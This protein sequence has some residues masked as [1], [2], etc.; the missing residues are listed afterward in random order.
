M[1]PTAGWTRSCSFTSSKAGPSVCCSSLYTAGTSC[2]FLAELTPAAL[3]QVCRA[4][5]FVVCLAGTVC[6]DSVVQITLDKCALL[7]RRSLS[8]NPFTQT[9]PLY[10]M[11]IVKP[12]HS[13]PSFLS[14][15]SCITGGLL[16]LL[17]H[18]LGRDYGHVRGQWGPRWIVL[19]ILR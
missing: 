2:P 18:M 16:M 6:L 9:L 7:D 11:M 5:L 17:F 4:A 15:V 10:T 1:Y 14:M 8:A 13:V 3:T 19:N 12:R